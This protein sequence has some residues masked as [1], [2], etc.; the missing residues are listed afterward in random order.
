MQSVAIFQSEKREVGAINLR[1]HAMH[2]CK[3]IALRPALPICTAN[4]WL[5]GGQK[6][7][8]N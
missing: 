8:Q 7:M 2:Y 1:A 3:G 6:F 4:K 5:V